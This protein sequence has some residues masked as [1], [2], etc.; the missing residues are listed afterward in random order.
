MCHQF[1]YK[2][3]IFMPKAKKGRTLP[4]SGEL[5]FTLPKTK[6]EIHWHTT[7]NIWPEPPPAAPTSPDIDVQ[8]LNERFKRER[9]QVIERRALLKNASPENFYA[10]ICEFIK[11]R[12]K[13]PVQR[14]ILEHFKISEFVYYSRMKTLCDRNLVEMPKTGKREITL[15]QQPN[16][17]TPL[18]ALAMQAESTDRLDEKNMMRIE[19]ILNADTATCSKLR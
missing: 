12:K 7:I 1:S 16:T 14:D 9:T 6:P 8:E 2:S 15:K 10:Y 3:T 11:T 4:P 13:N 19:N 18:F 5:L 17:D